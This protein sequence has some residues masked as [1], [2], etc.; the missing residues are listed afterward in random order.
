MSASVLITDIDLPSGGSEQRVLADAGLRVH[1]ARSRQADD[2][3][4]AGA[5]AEALLVQWAPITAELLDRLPNLRVISRLGI[6]YDMVDV[7]AAT[8]HGVAVCNTPD[9]CIEEV[10]LHTLALLLASVRGVVALD[11]AVRAGSFTAAL[12][13]P[14]ARRPS[15]TT[16]GLV[17]YGR[18][19]RR[20]ALALVAIGMRVLVAD[21][22]V[23]VAEHDGV[24][25]ATFEELL[26]RADVVS[27]HAPL[28]PATRHLINTAALERMRTGAILVNTCRGGLVD[29]AALASALQTGALA[30][31]ALDVF[32]KEPL[33][34]DSPL[35]SCPNVILTPHAAWYSPASL[36]D[37]PVLAA[38]NIVEFLA[39]RPPA[40]IVNPEYRARSAGR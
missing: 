35:R 19:G 5:D 11:A 28:T 9:Y 37:L 2:V 4:A 18:I 6:G 1:V 27:L 29:E 30:G 16:V 15:Q 8:H 36:A 13:F 34:A 23:T 25:P 33:P 20:V 31:C 40:S 26:A 12:S 7:D 38:R 3:V 39:G 24:E 17:G 21:P 22:Y 14:S 10:A 32:E